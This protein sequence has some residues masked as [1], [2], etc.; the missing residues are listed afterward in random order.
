MLQPG[1]DREVRWRADSGA[2]AAS[3]VQRG[4]RGEGLDWQ[5]TQSMLRYYPYLLRGVDRAATLAGEV[6]M[7]AY[8]DWLASEYGLRVAY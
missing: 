8:A 4:W 5:Q 1:P 7:R 6:D 3:S 2:V